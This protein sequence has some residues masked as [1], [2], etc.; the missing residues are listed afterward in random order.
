MGPY[1]EEPEYAAE[2]FQMVERMGIP[3]VEFTGRIQVTDYLGWM[4]MTILT[5]ISEGQP[6]TI[7][8]SFAAHVPVIATDVGNCRGLLHGEDDEFGDA[9][10]LTH[11]M[12]IEEIAN[13]MVHLAENP[14]IRREMA[15]AG[16]QRLIRKYKIED[17]KKTYEAIYREA[18][19]RQNLEWE[20]QTE[21]N[22]Q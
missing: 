18:A 22:R 19:Q 13:A 7:L 6:L 14:Q 17:M 16:Y 5:S 12:N 8:E 4:D 11:I 20:E 9:G 2:C 15:G 10:I 3:D 1:D 21:E